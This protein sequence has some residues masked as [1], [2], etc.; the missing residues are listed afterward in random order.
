MIFYSVVYQ[1]TPRWSEAE[2]LLALRCAAAEGAIEPR[3]VQRPL[4]SIF[5]R[6][7]G[8]TVS[9]RRV[10]SVLPSWN[11]ASYTANE[12]FPFFILLLVPSAVRPS[13]GLEMIST[14]RG[15]FGRG[16]GCSTVPAAQAQPP[17]TQTS[18]GRLKLGC[19][20]WPRVVRSSQGSTFK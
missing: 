15:E 11:S 14:W 13:V 16:K 18:H 4:S 6:Q 5:C 9:L 17:A 7:V 8:Y 19:V 3:T 20:Y 10:G 12:L 2:P 1:E